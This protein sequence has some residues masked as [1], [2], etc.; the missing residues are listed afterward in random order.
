LG[1]N[2][3]YVSDESY[4]VTWKPLEGEQVFEN[5]GPYQMAFDKLNH[6]LYASMWE[7][8]V[9]AMKVPE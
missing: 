4:G 1:K 6:I 9:W 7:Q 2:P 5:G 3:F 8:G